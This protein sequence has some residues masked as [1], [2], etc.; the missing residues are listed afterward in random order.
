MKYPHCP[1]C[2]DVVTWYSIWFNVF[3]VTF[4]GLMAILTNSAALVAESLHSMADLLASFVTLA[5]MRISRLPVNER[6]AYGYGKIQHISSGIVGLI[7]AG[8]SVYLLIDAALSIWRGTYEAP[9]T[10]ALLAAVVSVIGNELMFRY[11]MCVATENNSPAITAN[12]WDNRSDAF[13]SVGVTIGIFFATVLDFPVADPISA[14]VISVLVIKIGMDLIIEA[15]DNLMD[16]TPQVAELETVYQ[17]IRGFPLVL[18]IN[19]IRA[20][21][22]GENLYV[23]VDIRIDG[24]LKV[25]ESDMLLLTLKEKIKQGMG[26]LG[27]IIGEI[28]VSVTPGA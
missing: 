6:H 24:Q 26:D 15:V 7:L 5:S 25:F 4:K 12:A 3:L 20:R 17:I 8:G 27:A 9:N 19:Y 11:Q 22:L 10:T 16:A 2:R 18:G 1:E 13:S 14:I 23:E 28:R 21:S